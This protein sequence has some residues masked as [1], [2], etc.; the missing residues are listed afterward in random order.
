VHVKNIS[1]RG[2]KR[3]I[4]IVGLPELP[5][6]DVTFDQVEIVA[7]QGLNCVDCENVT[8]ERTRLI[9]PSGGHFP[10]KNHGPRAPVAKHD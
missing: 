4:D 6:R 9:S 1:A 7:D 3:A 10:V 8:F 5:I 2:A